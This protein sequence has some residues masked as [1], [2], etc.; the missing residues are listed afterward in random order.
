MFYFA[1]IL[2]LSP[3]PLVGTVDIRKPTNMDT[4]AGDIMFI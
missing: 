2:E 1:V 3:S 4:N